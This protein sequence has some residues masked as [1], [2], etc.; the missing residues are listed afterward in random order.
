MKTVP[1]RW[2]MGPIGQND[3]LIPPNTQRPREV[4]VVQGDVHHERVE[5]RL[6]AREEHDGSAGGSL[7]SRATCAGSTSS[8]GS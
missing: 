1:E 4:V 7:R 3:M 2:K 5:V 6:V 8:S